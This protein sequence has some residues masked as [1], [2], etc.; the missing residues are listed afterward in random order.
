MQ[1][2]RC[3]AKCVALQPACI[4]QDFCIRSDRRTEFLAILQQASACSRAAPAAHAHSCSLQNLA[5]KKMKQPELMF[6]AA[7]AVTLFPAVGPSDV[8]VPALS[9][10]VAF[11]ES[12]KASNAQT[13][14]INYTKGLSDEQVHAC[15]PVTI[16]YYGL[17]CI[18]RFL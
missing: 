7:T 17:I 3:C 2:S 16:P 5:L 14:C 12:S 13:V 18:L 9:I 6:N 4:P 10:K 11:G 8:P 15:S 1:P